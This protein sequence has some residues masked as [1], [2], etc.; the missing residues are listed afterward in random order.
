M[1]RAVLAN[2]PPHPISINFFKVKRLF[3]GLCK[4][5]AFYLYKHSFFLCFITYVVGHN[6]K[7][8]LFDL[9]LAKNYGCPSMN[10]GL[11]TVLDAA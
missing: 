8:A 6:A 11:S 2:V 9:I 7:I 1:G 5:S 4:G 3:L 10:V